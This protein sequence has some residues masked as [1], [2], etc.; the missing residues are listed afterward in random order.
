MNAK[1]L[2]AFLPAAVM[3]TLLTGGL[4][5]TGQQILR[6]GAN[7]PQIQISED[8]GA[9]IEAG[10][11]IPTTPPPSLIDASKSL[12]TFLMIFN[13]DGTAAYSTAQ[14]GGH[15]PVPPAGTFTTARS[16]GSDRFTWQPPSGERFAAVLKHF[17]GT[18]PGFVLVARSLK[19]VEIRENK[20]LIDCLIVWGAAMIT[21]LLATWWKVVKM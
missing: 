8:I 11:P 5:V 17:G 2:N 7:D 12:A 20:L 15:P 9:S 21:T 10:Q 13:E 4:Y 19:E 16:N 6:W 18:K 1:I 3:I 14:L